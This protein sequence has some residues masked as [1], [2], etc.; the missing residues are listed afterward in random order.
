[1]TL[2][3]PDKPPSRFSVALRSSST[4]EIDR[5]VAEVK[6]DGLGGTAGDAAENLLVMIAALKRHDRVTRGHAER[7]RAYTDLIA[8]EMGLTKHERSKLRWAALLHDVGN[9]Y[10]PARILNKT[11]S[12]TDRELDIGRMHPAL[13]ARMIEPRLAWLGEMAPTTVPPTTAPP[14]DPAWPSGLVA[15]GE[16]LGEPVDLDAWQD[17]PE[18][19]LSTCVFD[20]LDFGDLDRSEMGFTGGSWIGADFSN[21]DLEAMDFFA[22][23]LTGAVF[24]GANLEAVNFTS[25]GLDGASFVDSSFSETLFESFSVG[26]VRADFSNVQLN[27]GW[28]IGVDLTDADF[29]GLTATGTDVSSALL[30]GVDFVG[31]DVRG[32]WFDNAT[33]S[34]TSF[35]NVTGNLFL[36]PVNM[37]GPVTCPSGQVVTTP[38]PTGD[39]CDT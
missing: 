9:V 29:S 7:T 4:K 24:D 17:R 23:D 19:F 18:L 2:I 34:E 3:F 10:V 6:A 12:L 30:G 14:V 8:K 31:A 38:P 21:S 39:V 28:F 13:G 27:S 33:L 22:L 37:V 35:L 26:G 32:T 25:V 15:M 36:D 16:C 20:G 1:M 5:T 11:E